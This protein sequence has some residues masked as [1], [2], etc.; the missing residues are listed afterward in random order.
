MIF[1]DLKDKLVSMGYSYSTYE[2]PSG[3]EYIFELPKV[4]GKNVNFF[5]CRYREDTDYME[6]YPLYDNVDSGRVA[7]LAD[8]GEDWFDFAATV[9]QQSY[10]IY[11]IRQKEKEIKYKKSEIE[12]DFVK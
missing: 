7:Y 5:F 12:K 9:H 4:P 11:V 1:E 3:K 8:I 6:Y 2:L 10:Q